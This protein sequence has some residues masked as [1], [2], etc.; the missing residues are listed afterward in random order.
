M[1]FLLVAPLIL[2]LASPV[3][4]DLGAADSSPK[5]EAIEQT[6]FDAW[7]VKK[8]ADCLAKLENGR[9]IIDKGRGISSEQVI[10]WSR[11]DVYKQ[12][13]GLINFIG[14]HHLYVYIIRYKASNGKIKEGRIVFQNTKYADRFYERLKD[15][16][17]DKEYKCVYNFDTRKESC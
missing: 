6:K 15:W 16:S 12:P 2:A 10:N 13:T 7:C 1:R 4:A 8:Y 9:L 14:P 17:P 11:N 5:I 3:K